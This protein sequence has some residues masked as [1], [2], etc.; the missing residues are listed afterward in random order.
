M[1]K[2]HDAIG[3][4]EYEVARGAG[5]KGLLEEFQAHATRMKKKYPGF[6]RLQKHGGNYAVR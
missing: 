6:Q 2:K 1:A 4:L 3:K 5:T